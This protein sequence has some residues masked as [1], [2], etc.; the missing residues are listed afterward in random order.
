MTARLVLEALTTDEAAAIR[1]DDRTGRR[2]A[3]GY[4]TDG[5]R[6]VAAI[7]GEAGEHYDESSVLGPLQIRLAS[8]GEAVGGVGF[9]SAPDPDG[10][11]EVGYGLAESAQHLGLATEALSAAVGWAAAQG[12]TAVEAMTEPANTA[13]HRVLQ[14]CGFDQA[15]DV[16]TEEGLLLRWVR[17]LR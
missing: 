17:R 11:V 10:V 7:V 5:D 14:R 9:L 8:T 2:W 3:P 6:V 1:A 12:V 4:P 15:D 13:S 16:M